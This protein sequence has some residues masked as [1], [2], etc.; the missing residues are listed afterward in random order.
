VKY[1]QN[2][3]RSIERGVF[4]IRYLVVMIVKVT[5][6]VGVGFISVVSSLFGVDVNQAS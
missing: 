3:P 4:D 1:K 2:T 5:H 6:D